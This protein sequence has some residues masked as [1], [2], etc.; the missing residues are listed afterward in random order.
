[1]SLVGSEN[2]ITLLHQEPAVLSLETKY[3]ALGKHGDREYNSG[4]GRQASTWL[5]LTEVNEERAVCTWC[6]VV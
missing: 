1:M 3:H 6:G 5:S 2:G 4:A